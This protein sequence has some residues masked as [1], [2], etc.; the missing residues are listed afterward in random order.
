M[1]ATVENTD[2]IILVNDGIPARIW[3]GKT[4]NGVAFEMLVIRVA[5]PENSDNSQ[6]EQ[7]LQEQTKP[8]VS[9]AFPLRLII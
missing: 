5:V 2:Q 8:H 9:A 4:E 1:R 6:F 3:T 7:E